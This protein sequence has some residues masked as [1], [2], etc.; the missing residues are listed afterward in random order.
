[1][2]IRSAAFE[3]GINAFTYVSSSN[4]ES[5]LDNY[6]SENVNLGSDFFLEN[7]IES[8][9]KSGK[10]H[11]RNITPLSPEPFY[12][13]SPLTVNHELQEKDFLVLH[14]D[15]E[16]FYYLTEADSGINPLIIDLE[17]AEYFQNNEY[18]TKDK[19][20]LQTPETVAARTNNKENGSPA[21]KKQKKNQGRPSIRQKKN[22]Q[23]PA[24][25]LLNSTQFPVLPKDKVE[26]SKDKI[27]GGG[28]GVD[29]LSFLIWNPNE[30]CSPRRT[31]PLTPKEANTRLSAQIEEDIKVQKI[32]STKQFVSS[33]AIFVQECE[34]A[35][36]DKKNA[37]FL[38]CPRCQVEF[39]RADHTRRHFRSR[40][41]NI[42]PYRCPICPMTFS[43][44]DNTIIHM[45]SHREAVN[46]DTEEV[47]RQK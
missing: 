45:K 33:D 13:V 12:P 35:G 4:P 24:F 19:S 47:M 41:S 43:R 29:F 10:L 36:G 1:M 23:K 37:N 40:H 20:F 26:R 31:T 28:G 46:P 8:L 15:S 32:R 42:R 38:R 5:A 17:A 44:L 11:E 18:A 39:T 21:S 22:L 7:D 14:S 3:S 16:N 27:E 9:E 34:R 6:T 2:D 25:K 30:G